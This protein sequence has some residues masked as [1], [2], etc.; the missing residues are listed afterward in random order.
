M[1]R[2]PCCLPGWTPVAGALQTAS[3]KSHSTL[4][5]PDIQTMTVHVTISQEQRCNGPPSL[6][7][8]WQLGLAQH[9]HIAHAAAAPWCLRGVT[10]FTD[11]GK[12][13]YHCLEQ[14]Q[15][16]YSMMGRPAGK[17]NY[18]PD[19][20]VEMVRAGGAALGL[21]LEGM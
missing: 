11:T 16:Q 4:R 9:Q 15:E 12:A 2:W 5:I 7:L 19:D 13:T 14:S 6:M 3:C 18:L 10:H 17:V 1:L 8:H 21:P 20:A